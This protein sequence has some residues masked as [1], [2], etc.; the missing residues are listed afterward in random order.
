MGFA[1]QIQSFFNILG[2]KFNTN[3]L[4]LGK[5]GA[6]IFEKRLSISSILFKYFL[7]EI[8]IIYSLKIL[9]NC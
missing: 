4:L 7:M 5:D 8:V 2:I 3:F 1:N 6:M 9:L